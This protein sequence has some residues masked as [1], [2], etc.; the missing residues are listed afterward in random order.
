MH[1]YDYWLIIAFFALVLIPAPALG[2]FYY[3]VMEGQRT[4][5]TPVFGPVERVCYRLSGVDADQEQSWQKYALALLA[6][7]LAGFVLLFA[8]LLFQEYLPLNPQKL[9][10]QEWTL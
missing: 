2:R 3:K 7:N 9:P 4:W 8:I 6:F 10:G 1:S 5:L